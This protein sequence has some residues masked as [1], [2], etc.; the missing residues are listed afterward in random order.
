MG[1]WLENQSGIYIVVTADVKL[2]TGK[3][4][5]TALL[6]ESKSGVV[7]GN[8]KNQTIFCAIGMR[9]RNLQV[10]FGYM[11][12]PGNLQKM[13]LITYREMK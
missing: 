3:S 11:A 12:R 8:A 10:D 5:L 1:I 9:E 7:L 2:R 4:R 13:K 6:S